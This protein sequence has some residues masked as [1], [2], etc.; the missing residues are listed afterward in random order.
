MP[1]VDEV[2]VAIEQVLEQ[3]KEEDR[4][5]M[6][7]EYEAIARAAESKGRREQ[8]EADVAAVEAL[9]FNPQFCGAI[10]RRIEAALAVTQPGGE[11]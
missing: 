6:R 10:T 1:D 2:Q 8:L 5:W 3:F 7:E 11:K 9:Q 4:E